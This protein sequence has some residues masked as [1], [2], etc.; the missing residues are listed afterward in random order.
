MRKLKRNCAVLLAV[1]LLSSGCA[2]VSQRTLETF[3]APPI[4]AIQPEASGPHIFLPDDDF[5]DLTK[6]VLELQ[7]QLEKCNA[8][9]EV[10]NG[11][12]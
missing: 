2:G 6:Y 11:E 4:P 5:I 9:A 3:E 7:S 8:Q 10:F 12:R 1:A